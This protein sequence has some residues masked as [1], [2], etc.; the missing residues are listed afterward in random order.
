[1]VAFD[2]SASRVHANAIEMPDPIVSVRLV[3]EIQRIAPLTGST[4]I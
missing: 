4:L 3:E 2:H 1:M